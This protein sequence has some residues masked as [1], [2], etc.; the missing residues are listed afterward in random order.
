MTKAELYNTVNRYMKLNGEEDL[1]SNLSQPLTQC[2]L[3]NICFQ[4]GIQY[5][6][7]IG[8][9]VNMLENRIDDLMLDYEMEGYLDE[10]VVCML[11]G[12]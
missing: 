5:S 9:I 10:K 7:N 6:S 3:D 11:G 12:M 4:C 2:L 1:I 8:L